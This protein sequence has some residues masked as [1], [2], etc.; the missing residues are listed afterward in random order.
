[1]TRVINIFKRRSGRLYAQVVE[2]RQAC[3]DG[4]QQRGDR[5]LEF[6]EFLECIV[7]LSFQKANPK[8]GEVGHNTEAAVSSPLPGCLET[9]VRQSLLVNAKR[10]KLAL[11]KAALETDSEVA[12]L[13]PVLKEKMKRPF[14]AL[15]ATGVRTLFGKAVIM[16]TC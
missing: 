16:W 5:G 15:A 6:H 9:M 12:A 7:N 11:V 10:D 1:M 8:F 3:Y 4:R 2:G 14:E 13:M